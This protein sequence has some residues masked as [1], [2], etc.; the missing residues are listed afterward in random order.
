MS[1]PSMHSLELGR[2]RFSTP[3]IDKYVIVP[4]SA[5][6]FVTIVSPLLEFDPDPLGARTG[7]GSAESSLQAL[8]TPRLENK[9]VWP[10]L[11]AISLV[12]AVRN[13]SRLT[14]PPHIICLLAYLAFA[15]ASVLWA[16]RPEVS[17]TRFVLQVTILTSIL[18]PAVLAVRTADMMRGVFLCFALASILNFFIVLAQPPIMVTD[19]F[20]HEV[21]F[22]HPGYFSMKGTLGEFAAI[23]FLL[24]VHEM[25]YPGLRRALGVIVVVI[26]TYLMFVSDS[27][28]SLGIVLIAPLLAQLTLLVGKNRFFSLA[29]RAPSIKMRISPAI[30]LLPVLIC[31]E[32]LA[33]IPGLNLINRI[34]F[35]LFKNYTLSGR[36]VIWDFVNYEIG[37]RPLLGWGFQSFWLVG[38][39]APSVVEAPGWVKIMPSAHNG[40]LDTMLDTGYV[41]LALLAIFIFA[42]LHAIGR[43][44]DRD[45]ARAW[46]VLSLALFIILTNIIESGWMHGSDILWVPFAILAAEIGRYSQPFRPDGRSQHRHR[47]RPTDSASNPIG[48]RAHSGAIPRDYVAHSGSGCKAAGGPFW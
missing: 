41:G 8:M 47:L 3:M 46:L 11:A 35:M 44:A 21:I 32:V 12:L 31:Y 43:V 16:F 37:R 45:P 23:A 4:I 1:K 2:A 14:F 39:D 5:C 20:H 15:G 25:L 27:K 6:V 28:G 26:A 29:P 7:V 34:S 36:T 13:R 17:F 30:V 24:S 22:G 10:V 48:A 38:P 42:T 19:E 40:Y 9:I 18:L 33:R